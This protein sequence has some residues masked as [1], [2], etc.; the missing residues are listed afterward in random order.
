MAKYGPREQN[1]RPTQDDI[2]Y[3]NSLMPPPLIPNGGQPYD[4]LSYDHDPNPE[5]YKL[6]KRI[7]RGRPIHR[8]KAK[9]RGDDVRDQSRVVQNRYIHTRDLIS[10]REFADLNNLNARSLS[11]YESRYDDFPIPVYDYRQTRVFDQTD[12]INWWNSHIGYND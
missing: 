3:A 1:K 9:Y 10:L 7:N 4:P 6:L 2:E 11:V 8:E 12:L 5:F